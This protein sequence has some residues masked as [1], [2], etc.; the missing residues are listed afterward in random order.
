MSIPASTGIGA[1][2]NLIL[3][4]NSQAIRI[5]STPLINIATYHGSRLTANPDKGEL[6]WVF[7]ANLDTKETV[8]SSFNSQQTQQSR[9]NCHQGRGYDG[10]WVGPGIAVN[11]P[12]GHRQSQGYQMVTSPRMSPRLR[13]I[14]SIAFSAS[15]T[16]ITAPTHLPPL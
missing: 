8:S 3:K 15:T 4:A 12:E 2:D 13:I 7:S 1:S 11:T 5:A 14:C 9:T 6:H 10:I 16:P